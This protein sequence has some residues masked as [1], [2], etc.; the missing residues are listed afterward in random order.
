MLT[1]KVHLFAGT[2]HT[3]FLQICKYHHF[4]QYYSCSLSDK[5]SH[6]RTPLKMYK[7]ELKSKCK[8]PFQTSNCEQMNSHITSPHSPPCRLIHFLYSISFFIS[9]E[10]KLL[11]CSQIQVSTAFLSPSPEVSL[12]LC[13]ASFSGQK[14]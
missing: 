10:K 1:V 11:G 2:A 13:R 6:M 14:T 8:I 9:W 7:E 5:L 12:Q 4:F 3:P